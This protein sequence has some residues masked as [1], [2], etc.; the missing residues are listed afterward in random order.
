VLT[1]YGLKIAPSTYYDTVNRQPSRRALRDA[2]IVE[3]IEA[4]RGRQKLVARFGAR[5][6]WLYLRFQGH[7]VASARSSG[8]TASRAGSVRCG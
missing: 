5:K 7:D 6:M 4:E 2:E 3:A 8:S 1:G